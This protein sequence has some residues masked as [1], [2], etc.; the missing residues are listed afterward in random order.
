MHDER[1][2]DVCKLFLK[3]QLLILSVDLFEVLQAITYL[4]FVI[5]KDDEQTFNHWY[6]SLMTNEK[7]IFEITGYEF[8]V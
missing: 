6:L 4:R 7:N 1:D 5:S 8:G 3:I 2:Y